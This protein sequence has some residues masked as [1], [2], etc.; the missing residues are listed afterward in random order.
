MVGGEIRLSHYLFIYPFYIMSAF[1]YNTYL[2][3]K[4]GSSDEAE[5]YAEKCQ[6]EHQEMVDRNSNVIVTPQEETIEAPEIE[7]I[8]E[9]PNEAEKIDEE[10]IEDAKE[11][12]FDEKAEKEKIK[13]LL[14][15]KGIKFFPGATLQA[16]KEKL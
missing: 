7:T 3:I 12:I 15:A 13:A 14:K 9:K 11:D 10:P 16:L 2:Q 1:D 6:K 4:A 8:E 5:K